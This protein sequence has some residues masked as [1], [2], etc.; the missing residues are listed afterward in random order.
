MGVELTDGSEM[1]KGN[2]IYD[3][4]DATNSERRKYRN[5]FSK[6]SKQKNI[7]YVPVGHWV[8]KLIDYCTEEEINNFVRRQLNQMK[9]QYFNRLKPLQRYVKDH[10]VQEMYY[11]FN[12]IFSYQNEVE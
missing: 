11:N 8:Y 6:L 1:Y 9:T 3:L 2:I 10:K 4:S 12:T 5:Y 7:I